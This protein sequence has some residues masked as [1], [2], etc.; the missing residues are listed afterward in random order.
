MEKTKDSTH[1]SPHERM[2]RGIVKDL[3]AY[4]DSSC[5]S[6]VTVV[7]GTTEFKCHRVILAAVSQF[8]K[9]AFTCGLK[10][11]HEGKITLETVDA[12]TFSSILTCLYCGELNLTEENLLSF[13]KAAHFLQIGVA[14]TEGE[15]FF[16]TILRIDNCF[17]FFFKIKLLS[18]NSRHYALNF[19]ADNFDHFRQLNNFNRLDQ[20]DLKYLISSE[21][22]NISHEDDL[23]ENLLNWA[24]N[25]LCDI[26][27]DSTLGDGAVAPD[28]I[29]PMK[30]VA[31]I[32]SEA[33][34][35]EN[36][37]KQK[38]HPEL[39]QPDH[40]LKNAT[41]ACH[42]ADL[43]ERTRYF[44]TSRSFLGERLFCHPL[45]RADARCVALVERMIRYQ[46]QSYLHTEWCP[47]AAMHRKKSK[48]VNCIMS[49]VTLKLK[50]EQHW[51]LECYLIIRNLS[52]DKWLKIKTP[53]KIRDYGVQAQLFV[54]NH[55]L[56]AFNSNGDLEACWVEANVWTNLR[57]HTILKHPFCILGDWLY[58]CC[59]GVNYQKAKVIRINLHMLSTRSDEEL[60]FQQVG[61]VDVDV[62]S[63]LKITN[64]DNTLAM[65]CRSQDGVCTIIFYELFSR[66]SNIVLTEFKSQVNACLVT[67]RKDKEVFVLEEDGW[68]WRIRRCPGANA[69]E[70][71]RESKLWDVTFHNGY[72]MCGA[73]L[74]R[75]ELLVVFSSNR[76]PPVKALIENL[77][78]VFD[79]VISITYPS[80]LLEDRLAQCFP[81]VIHAVLPETVFARESN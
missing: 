47:P 7:A 2:A 15:E 71:V 5:F 66:K 11:E 18:Q 22:L 37:N 56:Y 26:N 67:L 13:W 80:N 33:D 75:D 77:A 20:E 44:L 57:Q 21:C 69:F 46:S 43:L 32:S 78:G 63:I 45:V 14:M 49:A 58:S 55:K 34:E 62:R 19:I 39:K 72:K 36:L 54:H 50:K 27:A 24:E 41:R 73:V 29:S 28:G 79:K 1:H 60:P 23:I 59:L 65:F 74:V 4:R 68:L 35:G 17:E 61:S 38:I 48:M 76:K 8:F 31:A 70:L 40:A 81:G 42:L 6:D 16:K 10:E 30:N 64:I 12:D 9:T 53:I 51:D 25:D 3:A 52:Q